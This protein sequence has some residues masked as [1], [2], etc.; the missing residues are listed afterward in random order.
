VNRNAVAAMT[1]TTAATQTRNGTPP[2]L[3]EPIM[4]VISIGT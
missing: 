4:L 1:T 2:I 3:R